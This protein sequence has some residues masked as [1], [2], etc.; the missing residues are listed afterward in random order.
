MKIVFAISFIVLIVACSSS[1]SPSHV[2][3]TYNQEIIKG[4]DFSTASRF[5]TKR[6]QQ[7]VEL[8]FPLYMKQM[9]KSRE[10]V[11]AFYQS[12][13]Q[14]VAKC[15]EITLVKESISDNEAHLLYA[16]KD[17][18]GNQSGSNE[19][20]SIKM[21]NEDGWKIDEIEVSL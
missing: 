5:Y 13:N 15:K 6:K 3:E 4:V 19:K 2:Y 10:D 7:E 1:E 12:F 9:K 11:I 14:S 21:V 8:K 20:Q 16:Q 18:C 17:I